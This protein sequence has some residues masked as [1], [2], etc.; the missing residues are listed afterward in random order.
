MQVVTDVEIGCIPKILTK[1]EISGGGGDFVEVA[2]TF[3]DN[4]CSIQSVSGANCITYLNDVSVDG[5]LLNTNNL[6]DSKSHVI[7]INNISL[8]DLSHNSY[9]YKFGRDGRDGRG[10]RIEVNSYKFRF[11]EDVMFIGDPS[12]IFNSKF[13]SDLI[14][15]LFSA[16]CSK[17]T[18]F[19]RSNILYIDYEILTNGTGIETYN[20][21]DISGIL[22]FMKMLDCAYENDIY[23]DSQCYNAI[24][25]TISYFNC[26]LK[27]NL[28]ENISLKVKI[29]SIRDLSFTWLDS[30]SK[31][32]AIQNVFY[33]YFFSVDGDPNPNLVEFGDHTYS[34]DFRFVK[35]SINTSTNVHITTPFFY[36]ADLMQDFFDNTVFMQ[37]DFYSL[38]S[39][40]S[41]VKI[42]GYGK[43]KFQFVN[44]NLNN[45]DFDFFTNNFSND[46]LNFI[47]QDCQ[48]TNAN[49]FASDS[50]EFSSRPTDRSFEFVNL[51]LNYVD[52]IFVVNNPISN[53]IMPMPY[54]IIN[55]SYDSENRLGSIVN[56]GGVGEGSILKTEENLKNGDYYLE[57]RS[58]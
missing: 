8:R 54:E 16:N 43:K 28:F 9:Y 51:S 48:I 55:Y 37:F 18:I 45:V 42:T 14:T 32:V 23:I 40:N 50:I 49:I 3:I 24:I 10:V 6:S 36:G 47:F 7:Y 56:I 29:G 1:E 15:P 58:T 31:V 33:Q 41:E 53:P 26:D 19:K 25:N 35:S 57:E 46:Y 38:E 52:I 5:L 2:A 11:C 44:S 22:G 39:Y 20:F 13:Y 30:N 17:L 21:A 34:A 12:V 4:M 27:S